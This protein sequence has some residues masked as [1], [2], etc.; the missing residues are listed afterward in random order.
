MTREDL[1]LAV[2]AA[3]QSPSYTPVQLQKMFFIL[4]KEVSDMTGGPHF[5]F[6]PYHYGPFDKAVYQVASL[7]ELQGT[8]VVSNETGQG[9][10]I[11]SLTEQG[12]ARGSQ[13]LQA[14]PGVLREYVTKVNG[15]V[16]SQ[17]FPDLVSAI[18]KAYPDM[19]VNSVFNK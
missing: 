5:N 14:L 1:F 8:L 13:L 6:Q 18:Y 3:N 19:K 7:H 17:S 16:K 15:F 9:I 4:D 11:Y 2:L 10:K 12:V